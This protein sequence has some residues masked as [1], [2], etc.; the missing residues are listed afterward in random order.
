MYGIWFVHNSCQSDQLWH[1]CAD[2]YN[3][4]AITA[5][6]NT[7]KYCSSS[8]S[9]VHIHMLLYINIAH[10]LTVLKWLQDAYLFPLLV[11]AINIIIN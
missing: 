8:V 10:E 5:N 3:K 7:D 9:T 11:T 6:T 2:C 1:G 4:V